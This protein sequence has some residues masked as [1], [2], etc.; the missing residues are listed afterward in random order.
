MPVTTLDHHSPLPTGV[1]LLCA[2]LG[3]STDNRARN[4]PIRVAATEL[5]AACRRHRPGTDHARLEL[6]RDIDTQVDTATPR[7]W[8]RIR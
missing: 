5:V 8:C 6:M 1:D 3:W 2:M 4:D 7:D